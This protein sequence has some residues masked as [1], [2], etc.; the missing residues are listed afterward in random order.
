V[1]TLLLD[2]QE[3]D[4]V[5]DINNNFAIASNPYS[6]A[7]DA[8]S[9]IKTFQ[10][11]VWYDTTLGVPYWQQ[12]LGYF[13]PVRVMK[14]AFVAAAELVPEVIEAQCFILAI[15]NRAVTGQVQIL[16]ASGVVV[17]ASLF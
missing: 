12:I 10:G 11:E 13:P 7:Q 5:L 6:L 14:T 16:D 17:A 4:I 8:A 1:D 9:E 15:T 3:W 2:D